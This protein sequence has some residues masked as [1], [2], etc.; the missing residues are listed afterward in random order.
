VNK[1]LE[2]EVESFSNLWTGGFIRSTRDL[3]SM[4]NSEK[5]YLDIKRLINTCIE[6]YVNEEST[7][8]DIGTDGGF[9]LYTMN[10]ANKMIG[11]DIRPA[12]QTSFWDHME[13]WQNN[14]SIN[15]QDKLSYVLNK[16][17]KCNEL[18][19]DSIDFVFSYDVFCHISYMGTEE[20]LK[21]LY[22]KL[23]SGCNLFIMIADS[24]K[25]KN[26]ELR[27]RHVNLWGHDSW[28]SFI[29][30][31]NGSPAPGRWY[32]Y[33]I[34]RFVNLIKKYGYELIHE[35]IAV[36]IDRDNPIIHFRKK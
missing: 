11:M 8:L 36:S 10:K 17:F 28:E 32:F 18:E 23:K 14:D 29:G 13:R 3:N 21:N 7:V 27:N 2:N 20:Y 33:G 30:D 31:Y 24:N 15:I 35:D 34:D 9:W 19:N 22:P 6:P 12:S 25:F 1:K 16:D 5:G 26:K 4:V